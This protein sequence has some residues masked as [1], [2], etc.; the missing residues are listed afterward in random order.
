[1]KASTIAMTDKLRFGPG[2]FPTVQESRDVV[3]AVEWCSKHGLKCMELEF[4]YQ[5]WLGEGAAAL[6]KK[7]AK[8][9]DFSF[10]A[11]GSYYINLN[12]LEA[13]KVHASMN[14]IISA[15]RALNNAGGRSV[16]FHPAFYLGQDPKKVYANVKKRFK[17]IVRQLQ[18]ESNPVRI[19]PETTGKPTQFGTYEE[20][21]KLAAEIDQ[22]GV[23]IDFA[24]LH[25]RTNGKYNTYE[26]FCKVLETVEKHLGKE[27][28]RDMHIHCSGIEYGPKGER[29]HLPLKESDLNIQELVKAWKDYKISGNVVCESP[30]LEKDALYMKQLYEA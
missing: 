28:L 13:Q 1:M 17:E 26:E 24:H 12:A 8:K 4:V 7:A 23:C 6:A 25:A 19:S 29:N 9:H 30:I 21:C 22:V 27:G 20:L 10:T 5:T 3:E 15:A 18:E 16:T 11:H 2:G 14:R